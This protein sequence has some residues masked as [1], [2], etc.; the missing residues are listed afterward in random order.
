MGST[1]PR[2]RCVGIGAG[3]ANLSLAALLHGD[4]ATPNL[5]IDRKAE[6]SWHDDQLVPGATL[7]VSLFKDLVSLSDPTSP[8]SFMAYLHDRG[9][10]YHY[11]NARFDN[12]PREEFRNYLRWACGRNENVVFGEE[13]RSVDFV[14]DAF[15]VRTGRRTL[16]S[17]N[18]VVGVGTAP[19]VPPFARRH[20]GGA[21]QF[22][23]SEFRSKAVGLR[24]RR[25]AVIG[26][27]QSGAEAFLD[28]ISRPEGELPHRVSWL[29]RRR[30]Y[31]PM[32]DSPF[33][34]EFYMPCHSDYFADL[35]PAV[36]TEFNIQ[37]VLTSDGIS[38]ATARR[39]YQQV[40]V[41]RFI[42]GAPQLAG[43]YPNREV[44][45][46][47]AC[48][49]D[50]WSISAQHNDLAGGLEIFEADVIIW[51]TGF[52]PARMDFLAPLEGRLER[53]GDEYRVDADFAARWDGPADRNLFLQNATRA[54]RGLAEVNLSLNAWRS[55]RIVDRIRGVRAR[56][57]DPAFVEW[58]PKTGAH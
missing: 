39:I 21:T 14:D 24:D 29:S 6:F 15:V 49:P 52:R 56:A 42:T 11:L 1:S 55:Q 4:P 51:A 37:H 3:P 26:G 28:L 45:S 12:V 41:H 31:F 33:T 54:Q 38:E 57:Q 5:I 2:Y 17:D 35:D 46:V 23:V 53:E 44:V 13:A 48:S 25:V 7:Q 10:I 16:R 43:L 27:G 9:R 30:N 58:S 22:H 34:N 50:G 32:D 20:L 40:Y 8:F 47:E 19:W 18:V 36:R